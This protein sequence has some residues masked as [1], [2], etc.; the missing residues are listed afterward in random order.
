[1]TQMLHVIPHI[2]FVQLVECLYLSPDQCWLCLSLTS[3]PRQV[4]FLVNL[5]TI[6]QVVC[7]LHGMHLD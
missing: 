7:F 1:M 6:F 2:A 3:R 5:I 4:V